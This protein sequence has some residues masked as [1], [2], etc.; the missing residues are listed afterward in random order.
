M[1]PAEQNAALLETA[2]VSYAYGS[3]WAVRDVSLHVQTGE[4]VALVGRNGAGKSTLLRCLAGWAPVTAG[5]VRVLGLPVARAERAVR[6]HVVLVPDTPP[7]YDEL[8]AWEH[9]QFV[10]QVRR[11]P[12]WQDRAEELL[13]RF[14][15]WSQRE[16]LPLAFSRGMRYKLAVCLGLLVA[17]RL[18]LLD[19][20]FGPLDP[21]SADRLWDDLCASRDTGMGILLSSHQL[22]ARAQPDRYLVMEEGAIIAQGDPAALRRTLGVKT[23]SLD[24]VLRAALHAHEAGAVNA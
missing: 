1:T 24:S 16:A 22:P 4:L 9:L 15:L 2:N 12:H 3:L 6:E 18:L 23:L 8:S 10:A 20:P 19:E 5:E 17:P 11:L 13:R 7:F 21:V 14:G